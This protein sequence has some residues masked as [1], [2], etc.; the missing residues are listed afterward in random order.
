LNK[1][2]FSSIDLFV[3]AAYFGLVIFLGIRAGKKKNDTAE[4]YFLAGRRLTIPGFVATLVATWYGGIL[5]IG[6]YSYQNGL[7]TWIVLGLPYYLFAAIFAVF[8]SKRIREGNSLTVP[9]MLYENFGKASGLFGGLL[10]FIITSPAAYVLM[11]GVLLNLLFGWGLGLS[12]LI[13]AVFSMLYVFSGGFHAIIATD[14]LQFIFMF[15]GFGL[16]LPFA[17]N[18]YGGLEFLTSNLPSQHMT[19]VGGKSFSYI[20][21]WFFIALWTIVD[22][23]FHQRC[24]AAKSPSIA[25]KGIFISIAFWFL[26]DLM[27]VSAGLYARAVL[28]DIEPLQAYPLLAELLLPPFIKGIFFIGLLSTIMSTIDSLALISGVTISKDII[29]RLGKNVSLDID[30]YHLRLGVIATFFIALIIAYFLPSVVGIWYT[31]GSLFIPALLI[32]VV[33]SYFPRTKLNGLSTFLLM[34]LPFAAA[35]IQLTLGYLNG[36]QA[37]PLYPFEIEPIFPGLALSSILYLL[38]L[39]KNRSSF[40]MEP[41]G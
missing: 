5:G 28:P 15:I 18:E 30:I 6:E 4:S 13:G 23:S 26:F 32:P 25:R 8:L 1:I 3:F 11:L 20:I 17:I 10:I 27:T 39:L 21:V 12:I 14:K 38:F 35:T 29:G 7:S 31:F 37:D 41:R 34:L 2:T 16:L 36:S 19:L 33:T 9:E 40:N 24:A 22:P